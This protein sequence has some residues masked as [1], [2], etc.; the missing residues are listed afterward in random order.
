MPTRSWVL[1]VDGIER[2]VDAT[3]S[4]WSGYTGIAVD[5]VTIAERSGLRAFAVGVIPLE[6]AGTLGAHELRFRRLGDE[7]DLV[8]DGHSVATG[9][10]SPPASPPP[11]AFFVI[12]EASAVTTFVAM[13]WTFIITLLFGRFAPE[14][15]ATWFA[16]NP[17]V[18]SSGI[19]PFMGG[20]AV[21]TLNA[22]RLRELD[23]RGR[24]FMA[25]VG[26]LCLWMMITTLAGLPSQLG[27]IA[28]PPIIRLAQ[29]TAMIPRTGRAPALETADSTEYEW[30]WSFGLYAYPLIRPGP[31]ELVLTPVTHHILAV[32]P[33]VGN[34]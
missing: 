25:I 33:V 15:G 13:L 1:E 23:T 31:C 18:L 28:S 2:R 7:F 12:A 14:W 6:I 5:G 32:H 16:A 29:V 24:G 9:E 27:D 21:F 34:D 26:L 17:L 3:F 4:T 11:D 10:V 19:L 30:Q 22:A 8:L 20:L